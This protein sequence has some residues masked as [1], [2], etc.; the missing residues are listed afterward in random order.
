MFSKELTERR[1][2]ALIKKRIPKIASGP[3]NKVRLSSDIKVSPERSKQ[4]MIDFGR[5]LK[6]KE[7]KRKKERKNL[8]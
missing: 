2:N 7:K 4:Q 3:A 1:N 5:I 6:K 8:E